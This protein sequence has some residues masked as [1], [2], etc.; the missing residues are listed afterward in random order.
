M[1]DRIM[2]PEYLVPYAWATPLYE[3]GADVMRYGTNKY[4]HS[5]FA[6]YQQDSG[7]YAIMVNNIG[8]F[9]GRNALVYKQT[10]LYSNGVPPG[11]D[12]SDLFDIKFKILSSKADSVL[13][14]ATLSSES[15]VSPALSSYMIKAKI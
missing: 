4:D 7:H 3:V 2:Y 1:G 13:F 8:D 14:K 10:N 5:R 6:I 9:L 11:I 15:E 12:L